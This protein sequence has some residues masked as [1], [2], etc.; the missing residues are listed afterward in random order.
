M[1]FC[2]LTWKVI[3]TFGWFSFIIKFYD[4]REAW[5]KWKAQYNHPPFKSSSL[6]EN[7]MWTT[8]VYNTID[9]YFW[10]KL[11]ITWRWNVLCFLLSVSL[12]CMKILFFVEILPFFPTLFSSTLSFLNLL[13]FSRHFLP[14]FFWR[15]N[16][17]QRVHFFCLKRFKVFFQQTMQG[18]SVSN[19]IKCCCVVQVIEN[20]LGWLSLADETTLVKLRACRLL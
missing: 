9:I 3:K 5:L 20:K 11:V 1:V 4:S 6:A 10:P 14:P 8:D 2:Q 16:L 17:L 19:A 18:R 15:Q 12:P 7:L 13:T